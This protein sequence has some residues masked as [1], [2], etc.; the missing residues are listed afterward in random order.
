MLHVCASNAGNSNEHLLAAEPATLVHGDLLGQN[1]LLH[2]T[3]P[4]T[5]IDWEFADL[6]DPA[7]D[8]A[9]VTRGKPKPFDMI[10]GLQRLLEAYS[11]VPSMGVTR[12]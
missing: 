7:Y 3:Q 6:G 5:V 11:G 10:K 4:P 8:L 9:V 1:I 2:P 12:R